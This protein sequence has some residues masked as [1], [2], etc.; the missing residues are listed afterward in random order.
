M[1]FTVGSLRAPSKRDSDN[2]PVGGGALPRTSPRPFTALTPNRIELKEREV[3]WVL[4]TS[5]R[6]G[7]LP[8]GPRRP[9]LSFRAR[10]LQLSLLG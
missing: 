2:G 5:A 4:T 10:P 7:L 8:G 9:E 6:E 3:G 1:A